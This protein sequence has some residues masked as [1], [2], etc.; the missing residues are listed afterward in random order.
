ML[1]RSYSQGTVIHVHA[2]EAGGEIHVFGSSVLADELTVGGDTGW[3]A[4]TVTY[5]A[6][7]VPHTSYRVYGLWETGALLINGGSGA[8]W[9]YPY[10]LGPDGQT[11]VRGVIV[12]L[13]GDGNDR[14]TMETPDTAVVTARLNSSNDPILNTTMAHLGLTYAGDVPATGGTYLLSAGAPATETRPNADTTALAA[15]NI[16]VTAL[17]GR[18]VGDGKPGPVYAALYAAYQ[19]AKARAASEALA[20]RNQTTA[21]GSLQG[22]DK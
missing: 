10:P 6:G 13:G 21:A 5:T 9:L 15:N 11:G 1:F 22:V 14:I 4:G 12:F 19:R 8:D 17:D 16:P 7:N 3:V 18:A 20:Q 2:L